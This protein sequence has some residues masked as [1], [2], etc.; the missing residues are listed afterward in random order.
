MS[1]K[2]SKRRAELAIEMKEI[3][4]ELVMTA[5]RAEASGLVSEADKRIVLD[6]ME[7]LYREL[8]AQYAEFKEGDVMLLQDRI[9]ICVEEAELEGI[10]KGMRKGMKKGVE[11]GIEKGKVE[12]AFDVARKLLERG[13]TLLEVAEIVELPIKKLQTLVP[14][15]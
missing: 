5:D 6:H 12:K 3:V 2:T 9:L 11:K 1:A 10:K 13:M 14:Q 7:R 15:Q 8:F 4:D